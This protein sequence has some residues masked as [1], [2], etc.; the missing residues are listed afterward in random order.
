MKFATILMMSN[1]LDLFAMH[2]STSLIF[3]GGCECTGQK[4][5][6]LDQERM[7]SHKENFNG[8]GGIHHE[9]FMTRAAPAESFMQHSEILDR[10]RHFIT[11]SNKDIR[12]PATQR[13]HPDVL[14]TSKSVWSVQGELT[15]L[16]RKLD[17]QQQ[18][19]GKKKIK[20]VVSV[21]T[22][23]YGPFVSTLKNPLR[24]YVLARGGAARISHCFKHLMSLSA[25]DSARRTM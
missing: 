10:L 21:Q 14:C 6:E 16:E 1:M 9:V 4:W 15:I 19:D 3:D 20:S 17:E 12:L 22:A 23:T 13:D 7:G 8:A 11:G 5:S 24:Y 2:P 25:G 18:R